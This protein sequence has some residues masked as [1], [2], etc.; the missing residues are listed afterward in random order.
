MRRG[1]KVA[2]GCLCASLVAALFFLVATSPTPMKTP[3]GEDWL[4]TWIRPSFPVDPA[5]LVFVGG[6]SRREPLVVFEVRGPVPDLEGFRRETDE[7]GRLVRDF[8]AA[9]GKFKFSFD[10]PDDSEVFAK[11]VETKTDAG[12]LYVLKSRNRA[13]VVYSRL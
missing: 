13:Y 11:F 12:T 10:V 9:A 6:I 8:K 1:R 3:P 7:C 5:N 4:A 2:I